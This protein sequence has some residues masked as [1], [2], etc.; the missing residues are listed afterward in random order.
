MKIN[1]VSLKRLLGLFFSYLTNKGHIIY[2]NCFTKGMIKKLILS[3]LEDI[4]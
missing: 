1:L 2:E 3:V 4:K